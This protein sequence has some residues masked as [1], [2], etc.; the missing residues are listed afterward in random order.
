MARE[1]RLGRRLGLFIAAV[2]VAQ[3]ANNA[4]PYFGLRDDSCQTMFSGLDTSAR[5]NNHLVF[6]QHS[7][8]DL[9]RYYGDV[10]AELTPPPT[11]PRS[12]YLA[13]WLARPGRRLNAEAVRVALGQICA[14]G[15]RVHLRGRLVPEGTAF[16][17]PNACRVPRFSSPHRWIP[18][19]LYDTDIPEGGF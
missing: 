8:G 3:T 15:H 18:V 9:W 4:L 17:A 13:S 1:E 10:D 6:G 16:D 2:C 11:D 12:V 7:V 5:G 19:R 14:A